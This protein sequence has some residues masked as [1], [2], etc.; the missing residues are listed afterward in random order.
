MNCVL[1]PA[2]LILFLFRLTILG[3]DLAGTWKLDIGKS[4]S[5]PEI[6]SQIVKID[7]R[8]NLEFL[9]TYDVVLKTG[10]K[11]HSETVRIFDGKSRSVEGAEGVADVNEH[12][13]AST[14]ISTRLKDG[15]IIDQRRAVL[16]PDNKTHTVHRKYIASE[17]Q[18]EEVLVFER[19]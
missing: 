15:K 10:Q 5:R 17:H 3:A 19:Q 12:P 8:A 9:F 16:A 11:Y 14:W 2:A 4:S 6:A 18:V 1:R 13:D 7:E